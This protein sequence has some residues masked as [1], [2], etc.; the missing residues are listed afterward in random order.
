MFCRSTIELG[1]ARK[2]IEDPRNPN[3]GA[4]LILQLI[5]IV[6]CK[7][8]G[9][10]KLLQE[11]LLWTVYRTPGSYLWIYGFFRTIPAPEADKKQCPKL[12]YNQNAAVHAN[13]GL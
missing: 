7:N 13:A 1:T 8:C 5:W 2:S 6:K 3:L 4:I 11:Q 10:N 12:L 9:G